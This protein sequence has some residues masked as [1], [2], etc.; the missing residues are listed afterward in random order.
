M[1]SSTRSNVSPGNLYPLFPIGTTHW[2]FGNGYGDVVVGLGPYWPESPFR[3]QQVPRNTQQWVYILPPAPIPLTML[4]V[5]PS[6][7]GPQIERRVTPLRR[8]GW[9][10]DGQLSGM[11]WI[12][13]ARELAMYLLWQEE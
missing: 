4:D 13:Y 10:E 11:W 12:G 1:L 8:W 2:A 3:V 5:E 7:W 9:I 6:V